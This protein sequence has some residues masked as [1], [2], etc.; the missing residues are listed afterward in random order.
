LSKLPERYRFFWKS[1]DGEKFHQVTVAVAALQYAH[2]GMFSHITHKLK[3]PVDA[4]V[5][6]HLFYRV[7]DDGSM[8]QWYSLNDR[9]HEMQV[10]FKNRTWPVGAKPE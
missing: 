6:D 8:G 5:V 3:R 7:N 4:V 1:V 2:L 10:H 9:E